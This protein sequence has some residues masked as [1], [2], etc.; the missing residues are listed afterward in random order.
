MTFQF[1]HECKGLYKITAVAED[2]ENASKTQNPK[3]IEEYYIT[4]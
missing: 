3:Q 4:G 2:A 1:A